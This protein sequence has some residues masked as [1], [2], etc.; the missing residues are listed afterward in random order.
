MVR[1]NVLKLVFSS[2]AAVYGLPEKVPV[3]ENHPTNPI[4]PYGK[5][6]LMVETII[7]DF[8]RAYGLKAVI[9][10]YFNAAGASPEGGVG[11]MH[12]PETH[13]IPLL[14]QV[15]SGRRAN[16]TIFGTDYD[17]LDGTCIRDYIH[18]EDIVAAHLLALEFINEK[19][20]GETFNLGSGS[21][22][23]VN[24]V[25]RNAEA[26]SGNSIRVE[27]GPRRQG[28]PAVLIADASKAKSMLQWD[29]IHEDI[30]TM[31]SHAWNWEVSRYGKS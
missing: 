12:E 18:V 14:L 25:L 11:E 7:E 23:S 3:S 9:L 17:T 8:K 15:A 26:V 24:E 5:S 29:P 6:K 30:R 27:F 21:G 4:N 31:I 19:N 13:L 10:R 16:V 1:H 2:T 28:D 20:Q 22:F